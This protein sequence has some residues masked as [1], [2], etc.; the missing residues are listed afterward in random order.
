MEGSQDQFPTARTPLTFQKGL[1]GNRLYF[2]NLSARR[3]VLKISR[4]REIRVTFHP[5]VRYVKGRIYLSPYCFVE[6]KIFIAD[7]KKEKKEKKE[8][9]VEKSGIKE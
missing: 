2:I 6:G 7:E 9:I 5:V 8:G 3:K 1:G 4:D